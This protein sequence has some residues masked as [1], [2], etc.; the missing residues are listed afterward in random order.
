MLW[1][2]VFEDKNLTYRELNPGEP[3][4]PIPANAGVGPEV[5]VGLCVVRSL[6][7]VVGLL[8]I[9]K[10]GGAY[11]P[12]DPA[13]PKKRLAFMLAD[14][15]VPVLLTEEK[16]VPSLPD[17]G[18]HVLCLDA[19]W[20]TI[21]GES[22]ENLDS[23]VAADNLA[24]VIYTSGSTGL[25]K[26]VCIP[27]SALA[28]FLSA[29]CERPGLEGPDVLAAIAAI[30]FDIA[31]LEVFL[32]LLVGAQVLIIGHE[33]AADGKH[34]RETLEDSCPSVI[35]ATPSTWRMLLQAG[36]SGAAAIKALSGGER[37]PREL[38]NELLPTVGELWNMYGPTET[39]IYSL[40]G[41]VSLAAGPVHLGRPIANTQAYLLDSYMQAVPIGVPGE[42]YIG[43]DGLARGYL[44]RPDL[45]AERFVPNPFDSKAS[46]RLYRTGDV[47]RYLPDGNIEFLGRTDHQVKIRGFRVE[48]GEIEAVLEQHPA[49]RQCVVLALGDMP[50]DSSAQLGADRRLVVY[51]V[52]GQ[53]PGPTV[54]EMR[55]FLREKLP[56]YMQPSGFVVLDALPLTPNGKIDREALPAPDQLRPAL[57]GL[58]VA[59]CTPVEVKLAEIWAKVLR[60]ERVGV[61]DSFFELG[62]HSLLATQIVSRIRDAF[63]LDLPLRSIFEMPTVAGLAEHIEVLGLL[64]MGR[65]GHPQTRVSGRL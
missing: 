9:L 55:N 54:S 46:T 19:D 51:I 32:P 37:L 2:S 42:L 16:L 4:G 10:A 47:A 31:T 35:Q 56:E 21:E 60:L 15:Q 45:T 7:M 6:E 61:H 5:T 41:R 17:N 40:G 64:A 24:Y 57:E 34:L 3:T 18:T 62:G 20:E 8:G 23:A 27:H 13:Y 12:L 52:P 14:S 36:W 48:L 58:F 50:D 43:G 65:Q 38:A 25:P 26:G 59:P 49:V 22:V 30:S 28:N 44:R 63:H 1:R 11:V 53:V 39:T 29:M 33:L